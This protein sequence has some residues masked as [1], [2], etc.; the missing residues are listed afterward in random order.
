M[1]SDLADP[2]DQDRSPRASRALALG[3]LPV[4]FVTACSMQAP[5]A[6]DAAGRPLPPVAMEHV[7]MVESPHGRRTDEY[8]W[9]R[10][11][12][13]ERKRDEVMQHLRAEQ[14]YTE[15]MLE[16]LAPLQERLVAESRARIAEA[17]HAADESRVKKRH[18]CAVPRRHDLAC[19]H[20]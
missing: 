13:P 10:D 1:S 16:R 14:A 4:A 19:C 17:S 6:R 9:L 11:D 20:G 18:S 7:T 12:H 5:V 8:Y 2:R 15:A 3:L